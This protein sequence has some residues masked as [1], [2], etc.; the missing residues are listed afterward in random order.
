MLAMLQIFWRYDIMVFFYASIKNQIFT[1]P[2]FEWHFPAPEQSIAIYE[3][4]NTYSSQVLQFLVYFMHC[5]FK[6]KFLKGTLNK[7]ES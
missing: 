1:S 3:V 7:I 2:F 4:P 6:M 5:A